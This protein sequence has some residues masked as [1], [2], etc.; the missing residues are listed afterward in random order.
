MWCTLDGH[1]PLQQQ[2]YRSVRTLILAGRLS[3]GSRL[4][5]TRTLASELNVSRNTVLLAFD[6]LMSEGYLITRHGSGTF[7]ARELPD[8]SPCTI[9]RP[10]P[11]TDGDGK[12]QRSATDER[13]PALNTPTEHV[14]AWAMQAGSLPYDFRLGRS[15]LVDFPQ[16]TWARLVAR[17]TRRTTVQDL[18]YP[19]VAGL[20]A[21]REEI[22]RYLADARGVTCSAEDILIVNGIQQALDLTTRVLLRPDS[23]VALEEPHYPPA[24]MVFTAA[25]VEVVGIPVDEQGIK[26]EALVKK[27]VSARLVYVTPSHQFP[28]GSV[29]SL[30][31]RL[32]LLDWAERNEAYIFEDDYDGEFRYVGRPLQALQGIDRAGRVLY[33]GTF[34]KSLFPAL[35]LGYLV[36][37]PPLLRA[38]RRTKALMD[39]GTPVFEQR[40]LAGFFHEGYFERHARRSRTLY[41]T[42]RAALLD[43]LRQHLPQ[44]QVRGAEA[45]LHVLVQLPWITTAHLPEVLQRARAN[46]VG[47]YPVTPCYLAPPRQAALM[48]GY[49]ALSERA[50]RIGIQR[51]AASLTT[52]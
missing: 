26:V 48:L 31:R 22:A 35:R 3:P 39:A 44:A 32:A 51:L 36:L 21:L 46:G 33:A 50:I 24:R 1:G 41:G 28:T 12:H 38:F 5:S 6:Q 37:P 40:V 27:G 30:S 34:S 45:G 13:P 42:R 10:L 4:P 17:C 29:M 49:T 18:D 15:S 43:A 47:V 14:F 20:L 23:V 16:A 2:L 8:L 25:N 9:R 7:V 11:I 52:I 19:A